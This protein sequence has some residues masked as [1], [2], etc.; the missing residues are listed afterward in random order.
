MENAKLVF[1][2]IGLLVLIL[3]IGFGIRAC[4]QSTEGFF[5]TRGANIDRK[6]FKE[7]TTYNEGKL[8]DLVKSWAEFNRSKDPNEKEMIAATIRHQFSDYDPARISDEELSS[9]LRAVRRG[10]Y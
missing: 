7:T 8:Q 10:D 4:D 1:K 2:G 5:K 3:V 6:V 9:F